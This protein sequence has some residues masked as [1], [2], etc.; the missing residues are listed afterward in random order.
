MQS[1]QELL[2]AWRG[3]DRQAANVLFDRHL[4]PLTRFFRRRVGERADDLV[5]DTLLACVRGRDRFAGE[6]T[7][8]TYMFA[9]ARRV[10]QKERE[11]RVR[12][13]EYVEVD[14]DAL[15]AHEASLEGLA[16]RRREHE[17]LCAG[18]AELASDDRRVLDLFFLGEL[19][20]AQ[21]GAALGVPEPTARSRIRLALARLRD[22]VDRQARKK[23][24]GG[25]NSGD[26]VTAARH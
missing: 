6:S 19:T 21:V 13:E 11:D 1:D 16:A 9:T 7:F 8:R 22:A 20:G 4:A 15:P 17:L 24:S 5:Q 3:G 26:R 25:A 12:R 10:L 14:A 18:Y 23:R 2:V